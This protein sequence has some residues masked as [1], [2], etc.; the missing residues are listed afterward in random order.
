MHFERFEFGSIRIDGT[1]YEHDVVI[2][3]GQVRRRKKKP[4]KQFRGEFG[5]TPLSTE[6]KIPW[7]C[8][9]LVIG[10]GTGALPVMKEVE[11][12]ARRRRIE[13][14]ILPTKEAIEELKQKPEGTNAVLHVTC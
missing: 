2:D 6:E 5:H 11:R 13:L 4:S 8:R 1:T 12:E 10:T 7:N 14:L 3:R 9:R